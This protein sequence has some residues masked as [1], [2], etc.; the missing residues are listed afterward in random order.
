MDYIR[1]KLLHNSVGIVD[2]CHLPFSESRVFASFKLKPVLDISPQVPQLIPL[3]EQRKMPVQKILDP[4][5]LFRSRGAHIR[6]KRDI[7]FVLH[8]FLTHRDPRYGS[9]AFPDV[10]VHLKP[11]ESG[12]TPCPLFENILELAGGK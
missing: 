1:D 10:G 5:H 12:Q 7:E 11:V 9:I 3:S 6:G 2:M 4:E 8:K